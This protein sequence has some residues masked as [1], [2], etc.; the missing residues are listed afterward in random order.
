MR[1]FSGVTYYEHLF[2]GQA[3]LQQYM[4]VADEQLI[5]LKQELNE[6]T[7]RTDNERFSARPVNSSV[8]ANAAISQGICN[9]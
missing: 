5:S 1:P 3:K 7:G 2:S 8:P 6:L 4:I 9:N